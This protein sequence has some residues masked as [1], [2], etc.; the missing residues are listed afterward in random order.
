MTEEERNERWAVYGGCR[1]ASTPEDPDEIGRLTTRRAHRGRPQA[2]RAGVPGGD[3]VREWSAPPDRAGS[4]R[5]KSV[6][7]V[8]SRSSVSAEGVQVVSR[9]FPPGEYERPTSQWHLL[10]LR[11][12]GPD[13]RVWRLDGLTLEGTTGPDDVGVVAAGRPLTFEVRATIEVLSVVL[14]EGFVRRIAERAGV[15]PGRVEVLGGPSADDPQLARLVRSFLP[16]MGGGGLGGE[17][18]AEDVASQLAV[19]LLRRH[20]SLGRRHKREVARASAGPVPKRAISRAL[21]YVNDNLAGRLSLKEL[22]GAAGYSPNHFTKLFKDATGLPPHRYV[23][24]RR[25]EMAR[26]LLEGTELSLAEVAR[27]SGFA[28]QSHMGRAVKALTGA[29]PA[30]LRRESRR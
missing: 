16:E 7:E 3:T 30:R 17:L 9:R 25:V 21:D 4:R 15:D 22:A 24:G 18:H 27:M 20:S 29:T 26:S 6:Y 8:L 13:R 28:S 23:V 10:A 12:S 5:P 19:H 11:P 14:H 1:E 2:V